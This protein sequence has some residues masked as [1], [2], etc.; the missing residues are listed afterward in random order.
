MEILTN[1]YNL[2][3]EKGIRCYLVSYRANVYYLSKFNSSNAYVLCLDGDFWFFTDSRY[4]EGAKEKIK[5]MN[6][7]NIEGDFIDFIS[8]FLKAKNVNTIYIDENVKYSFYKRLSSVL[9][10]KFEK[11][12]SFSL[13][14][15]KSKDE[16][17]IIKE[18][19][20]KT[21]NVY[22]RFLNFVKAGITEKDVKDFIVCEFL[23]EKASKESFD[24]IVASYKHSSVP[25]HET[26]LEIIKEDTP[27]LIDM[28]LVWNHYMSDF[29]RTIH[30][31]KPSQKFIDVYNIV[32]DAHLLAVEKAKVDTPLKEVD[33]TVRDYISKYGYGDFFT[34]STGHGIGLEIHEE[35]RVYK[36]SEDI[37][38]EGFVFT[39]EPGIYIP[40]SFGVR[41]EN[42]VYI[43]NG[44]ANI[45]SD[46]PLD[47]I[48]V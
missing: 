38:K 23:K 47:L 34:H 30:I 32:K 24:T 12:P 11:D 14:M 25:H 1:F 29:T 22:R 27:L 5:H 43:E 48:V 42:I 46:I 41:L 13:R 26:S 39:I 45:M 31:G 8:K 9:E 33:L 10:V 18:A 2:L 6:V 3:K 37:I 36:T 28:G 40:D 20:K 17:N 35:P 4:I 16:I 7:E 15:I 44:K 21:D 19:V